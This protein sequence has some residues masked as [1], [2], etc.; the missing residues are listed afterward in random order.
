MTPSRANRH[1]PGG[2]RGRAWP[3]RCNHTMPKPWTY[4]LN[5]IS[6]THC[7]A[8]LLHLPEVLHV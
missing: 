7:F 8:S 3:A 4:Q 6:L 2:P 5:T 1:V